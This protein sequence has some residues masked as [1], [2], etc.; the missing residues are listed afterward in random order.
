MGP[1]PDEEDYEGLPYTLPSPP[2]SPTKPDLSYAALVGRAILSSPEHRLTLQEIYEWITIVHPYFK[3]GETTWMNSIRHVLSTT[4]VFRKV[5]RVRAIGR[6]LWAIWDED[7]ECFAKG[8][9][10]KRFCKDMVEQAKS[11]KSRKRP[12]SQ[13]DPSSSPE[14]KPKRSRKASILEAPQQYTLPSIPPT[15]IM[16]LFPPTRPTTHLQ[17]Y[18]DACLAPPPPNRNYFPS[19]APYIEL[20]QD[21]F[22]VCVFFSFCIHVTSFCTFGRCNRYHRYLTAPFIRCLIFLNVCGPRTY[23]Q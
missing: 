10:D 14:K 7:L 13:E 21:D 5:T 3:R 12:N 2:Y 9:F 15:H 22:N 11:G 20:S 17:T 18:Y 16:P 1:A 4:A 19:I 23:A 6:T 8:S